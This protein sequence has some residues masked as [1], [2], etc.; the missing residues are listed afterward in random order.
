M[1]AA[2]DIPTVPTQVAVDEESAVQ[3]AKEIGFPVGSEIV[4]VHHHAQ[5][6]CGRR[7]THLANEARCAEAF[8]DIRGGVRAEE[9]DGVTVQPMIKLDGYE[10]IIG[11][12]LGRAVW[13]YFAFGSGGQLVEVFKT[14]LWL[15]HHFRRR[16]RVA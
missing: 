8:Q 9:F 4:F 3:A 7:K 12:S 16:W 13:A 1:L 15:C 10:I 5:N 11:S 6:R 2:Y 14:A